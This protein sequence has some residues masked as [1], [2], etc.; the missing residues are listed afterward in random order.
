MGKHHPLCMVR[1]IYMKK[2]EI[3]IQK[4]HNSLYY[5]ILRICCLKLFTA[6]YA[7]RTNQMTHTCAHTHKQRVSQL[8]QKAQCWC[9]SC[10][11]HFTPFFSPVSS[12]AYSFRSRNS[13]QMIKLRH[14]FG[15]CDETAAEEAATNDEK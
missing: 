11:E 10:F 1:C 3:F 5:A 6:N 12:K 8:A 7:T 9:C 14:R 13:Q 2:L 15:L 4:K